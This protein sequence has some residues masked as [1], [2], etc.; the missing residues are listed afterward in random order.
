MIKQIISISLLLLLVFT[1][2]QKDNETFVTDDSKSYNSTLFGLVL[3]ENQNPV[4]G[5]SVNY[6]NASTTTDEYGVY[7][8]ENVKVNDQHNFITI[9][10]SGYFEGCRTFRTNRERRFNHTTILLEKDFNKNFSSASG[11]TLTE[12]N[13]N[14]TFPANAIV[15]DDSKTDYSGTVQVAIKYLNPSDINT[16][17]SMPGDLTGITLNDELNILTTYGMVYVELQSPQGEKLQLKSDIK[18]TMT[19]II[20]SELLS[21]APNELPMWHFDNS[22]GAWKQEGIAQRVGNEYVA[23]V[24]HFSCWNY[25]YNAPSIVLSGRILDQDN[26]PLTNI[27]VWVSAIGEYYGGHGNTD[28]EGRFSG[29]VAKDIPLELKIFDFASGC[30]YNDPFYVTQIGPFNTDTDLGDITINLDETSLINAT[31]TLLDCNGNLLTNGI[32][33]T[34]N[35]QVFEITDGT[36]D[37]SLTTCNQNPKIVT[38]VDRDLLKQSVPYTINVGDNDLGTITVC[39]EDADYITIESAALGINY[40]FVDSISAFA[41]QNSPY[42]SIQGNDFGDNTNDYAQFY[43]NYLDNGTPGQFNE[44]TFDMT[45]EFEFGYSDGSPNS[46]VGYTLV[47]GTIEITQGGGSGDIIKGSITMRLLNTTTNEESDFTGSF[48][49]TLF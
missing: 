14:L 19:A 46:N 28:D 43:S 35:N 1:G 39:D 49:I 23:E 38:F 17:L 13:I 22:A 4:E 36:F 31:A 33:R 12:G 8:I 10:K 20:P 11:G 44:G 48:K 3:D 37:V 34:S 15:V 18:A 21:Q 5:A 41:W 16:S 25:D 27:H 26:K 9:E 47:N 45:Q 30:S 32:A 7:K 24:S 42:R 29:R 40:T 2:C 6:K